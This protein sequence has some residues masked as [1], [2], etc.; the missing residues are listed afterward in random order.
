MKNF[1]TFFAERCW[2]GYKS[3][4]GKKAYSKGSCV[5]EDLRNWFNPSHP[6]GGWKRINSKGEAIGP[7]AREPGEPKPKCMSNK[8]RAQLTKKERASA[9]AAKR[10]NDPVADRSG[11][12]GKPVNVSNFGKGKI[13][14]DM[15]KLDEKNVPT[16]PEKW[17][18][19][20]AQAK[21]KFDVYP[22]AYANG[23]AAKKYKEM[24]GGWKTASES[25]IVDDAAK[26]LSEQINE[27]AAWQRKEGKS[28]SGGLNRKGIESYRRENPGSKLSMAVTTK[29]SK[30]KAGSKAANRRKSFCA[31]MGGMKKRL[32]S[33]KTARDPDSRINKALRKWNC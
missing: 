1:K 18:R 11:K 19:A 16:S 6:D 17:A 15:E 5:K 12:G 32:T 13:S 14:E 30:L 28:E 20:K 27:V 26:F 8:K 29:P 4:P 10:R 33:A 22:S 9:V 2:P 7:C 25:S 24:G 31:R 23:W 3:V 21:A